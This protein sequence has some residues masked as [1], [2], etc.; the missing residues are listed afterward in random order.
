VLHPKRVEQ[1]KFFSRQRR[2]IQLVYN[3]NYNTYQYIAL[4]VP[5]Y[6]YILYNITYI[7]LKVRVVS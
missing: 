5:I 2:V 1:S 7:A 6:N 4:R 3:I